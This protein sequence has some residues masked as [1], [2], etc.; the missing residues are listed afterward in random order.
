MAKEILP[1][2]KCGSLNIDFNDCG[3]SSFNV[4]WGICLDCENENKIYPCTYNITK[5]DIIAS[6]N[7]A[8]DPVILRAKYESDISELKL[9]IDKL[10]K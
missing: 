9:K 3:Y 1:C 8:N 4:A 5:E 6:W 10:P 7:N 2:V